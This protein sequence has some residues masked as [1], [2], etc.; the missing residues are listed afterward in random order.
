MPQNILDEKT[1]KTI[2]ELFHKAEWGA[3]SL[4]DNNKKDDETGKVLVWDEQ[5]YILY[6]I[7][8]EEAFTSVETKKA[9]TLSYQDNNI[10][11]WLLHLVFSEIPVWKARN[12]N[13]NLV[14]LDMNNRNGKKAR[15]IGVNIP[16]S[17][18]K[19]PVGIIPAKSLLSGNIKEADNIITML[20]SEMSIHTRSLSKKQKEAVSRIGI[21]P[22]K[23]D[24][25]KK[26]KNEKKRLSHS[27]K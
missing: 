18:K 12:A 13:L 8:M 6:P 24:N 23:D 15:V 4:K 20:D 17:S 16:D 14:L 25:P 7:F 10:N 19:I 9:S 27:K 11:P 5:G 26:K 2:L 22:E 3:T 1:E 21:I